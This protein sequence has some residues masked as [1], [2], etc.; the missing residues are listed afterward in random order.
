MRLSRALPALALAI[1]VAPASPAT[2]AP[3]GA[4]CTLTAAGDPSPDAP[5][6]TGTGTLQG[7]PTTADGADHALHCTVQVGNDV[8]SAADAASALA[9]STSGVATLQPTVVSVA[10]DP[11]DTVYVCTAV[12]LSD[13]TSLHLDATTGTWVADASAARCTATTIVAAPNPP[14]GPVVYGSVLGMIGILRPTAAP[15]SVVLGGYL[16][17]P[18]LFTCTQSVFDPDQPFSVTCVPQPSAPVTF[19]CA[20]LHAGAYSTAAAVGT[21]MDCDGGAPEAE[22]YVASG[23]DFDLLFAASNVAVTAF[24]CTADDGAGNA[25][26]PGTT[27]GCGDPGLAEIHWEGTS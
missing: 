26:P 5:P 27:A 2:A 16:D 10:G 17:N 4:P 11:S 3:A 25:L 18:A 6:G 9:A 14:P 13:G 1:A 24:T 7:G 21:R 23:P 22:A 15:P 12:V 8:H 20:V 19:Y